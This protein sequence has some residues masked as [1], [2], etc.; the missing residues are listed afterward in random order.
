[1]QRVEYGKPR[2]LNAVSVTMIIL[3]LAFGYWMWRFFPAYFDAWTVDHVLRETAP[4]IYRINHTVEPDRTNGMRELLDKAK[5]DIRKQADVTDPDLT[6]S[7]N[8]DGNDCVLTADYTVRITHPLLSKPT[9]LK[10][11]R[12]E[13][14]DVKRVDW[15][16]Q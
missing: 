16:K 7:L 5:A 12:E 9:L 14:A 8:I 10:M 6:L 1:M 13:H 2:R 15:D 3:A 11:H 4:K